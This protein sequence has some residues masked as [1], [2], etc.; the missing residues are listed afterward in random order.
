MTSSFLS[1]EEVKRVCLAVEVA[2]QSR[3]WSTEQ[4]SNARVQHAVSCALVLAELQM[5][6]EAIIAA[7][8]VGV[9]E[10]TGEW[11]EG[12]VG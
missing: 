4:R 11:G 10:D 9:C 2:Y 3:A 7:L 8:L 12:K 6:A 1:A 5:E